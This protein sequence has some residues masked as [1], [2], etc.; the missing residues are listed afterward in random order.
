MEKQKISVIMVIYNEGDKIRRCL[1]NVKDIADEILIM[2][3]GPCKDNT[4]KIS[5]EYTKKVIVNKANVGLPGPILPLLVK[6]AKG[7]WILKID[8]DEF[9][10]PELKRNIKRL[11]Q[12]P[13]AD[14]YTFK[15]LY[16]VNGK[17]ITKNWPTKT[18]LY[19]KSKISLLGFPHRDDPIIHGNIIKT[20]YSLEHRP[21]RAGMPTLREFKNKYLGRYARLQA[22][23]TLK[24]FDELNK[25][26]WHEKDF[27]IAIKIRRKFPLLSSIPIGILAFFKSLFSEEAWKEGYP[28]LWLATSCLIYYPYVGYLIYKLKKVKKS[29]G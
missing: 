7:P 24:D 9:L 15:W 13:K 23:Y 25:F 18:V 6:K 1:E 10:S 20:D 17:Y 12:N 28:A 26:Q 29:G 4:I 21:P 11:A 27:S 16:R 3:D 19:R 5:K 22:E 14:A 8:A 2:H